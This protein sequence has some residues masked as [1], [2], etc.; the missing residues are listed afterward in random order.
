MKKPI[1]ILLIIILNVSVWAQPPHKFSYQ[2]MVR[3]NENQ[4]V[5]GQTIGMQIS[6]LQGTIF[7]ESVYIETQSP[8]TNENGLVSIEIGANTATVLHGNMADIEWSDGNFY[9][10]TEID[11]TGGT[12]YTITST[13]QLLSVPYAL[14][15]AVADSVSGDIAEMDPEF[16]AWDKST[17]ISITED[18]VRNLGTY[19][20]EETDPVYS[21]S[22]ASGITESDTINWRHKQDQLTAGNGISL[23]DNVISRSNDFYLGQNTL[24]G[25]VYYIYTGADN[26]RHGLIVSKTETS[27]AW[28]KIFS[29]TNATRSWDGAFNSALMNNSPAKDSIVNNFTTEWYLP[30][31]DEL[32]LLWHNRFHV[33]KSLYQAD[34]TLLSENAIYWSSSEY[35]K[36]SAYR[37]HF[38]VGTSNFYGKTTRFRIRAVRSF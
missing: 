37:L 36:A 26:Q 3:D 21:S 32:I 31:I 5:I 18:Q 33:N 25:I 34:T 1:L 2:A 16:L 8:T 10:K 22:V 7:G 14:Y 4:L 38:N 11:P 28:Q 20:V 35:N 29:T 13:S 27:A 24:G 12:V 17:G 9:I 23:I 6:I 30:S 15:S 19:I